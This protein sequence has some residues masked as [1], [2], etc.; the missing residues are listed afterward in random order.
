MFSIFAV[1]LFCP[2]ISQPNL[3]PPISR[4]GLT[5]HGDVHFVLL[6]LFEELQGLLTQKAKDHDPS[7][8]PE[9]HRRAGSK[10]QGEGFPVGVCG[11]HVAQPSGSGVSDSSVFSML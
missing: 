4:P 10:A 1:I 9:L 3:R 5:F 6:Q 2:A 7:Q 11:G 8:A